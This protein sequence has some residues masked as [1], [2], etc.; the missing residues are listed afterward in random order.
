MPNITFYPDA[1]PEST[2][3]DGNVTR[4]IYPNGTTW[5]LCRG[6][7]GTSAIDSGAF[8]PIID[9]LCNYSHTSWAYLIRSY[10][11]F[12]TS[13]LSALGNINII[14]VV[15]SIRGKSKQDLPGIA[16]N[17]NI[18]AAVPASNTALVAADFA[19]AQFGSTPFCD[20]PITYANW[21]VSD[22]NAFAFNASGIAAINKTGISKFGARNANYDVSGSDPALVTNE[23]SQLVGYF[24]EQG[25][26]YKPKLVVTYELAALT[27]PYP[28]IGGHHIINSLGD[29]R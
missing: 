10:F 1:N 29:R 8:G 18:Y 28:I 9:I 2:S 25:E 24:S 7:V 6:G 23:Y 14:A 11:L 22:Y 16:P 15:L 13:A 4:N 26:G 12:D 19:I 20:T 3:V 5:T 17:I 21:N 27:G